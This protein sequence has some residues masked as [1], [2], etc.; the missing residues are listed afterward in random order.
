M[1]LSVRQ[2]KVLR[3]ICDTFA[4]A[5]ERWPSASE[6][7]LPEAIASGLD[8][9]PRASDREQFLKLLD[10]W[11]SHL[12]SFLAAGRYARFSSLPLEVRIRVLLFWADS[13]LRKRRS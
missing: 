3:S 7:G 6:L 9:N 2:Q 10:F 1:N 12:H 13:A 8:F 11:D 5:A 4:P